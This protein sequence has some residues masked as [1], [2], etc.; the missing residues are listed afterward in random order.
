[1]I[2]QKL[3]VK[4]EKVQRTIQLRNSVKKNCYKEYVHKSL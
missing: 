2:L 3:L 4:E 1:M